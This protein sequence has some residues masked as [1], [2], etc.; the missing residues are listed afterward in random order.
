VNWEKGEKSHKQ[1]EQSRK[2]QKNKGITGQ[3]EFASRVGHQGFVE[4][5]WFGFFWFPFRF[6][7]PSSLLLF[8]SCEM[9]SL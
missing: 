9:Y 8:S 7:F 1:N 4:S 6:S 5:V 2:P 3:S